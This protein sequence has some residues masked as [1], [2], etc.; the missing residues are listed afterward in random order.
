MNDHRVP[1][2]ETAS[3]IL[4]VSKSVVLQTDAYELWSK[5]SFMYLIGGGRCCARTSRIDR[6]RA[7]TIG[8]VF[9]MIG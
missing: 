3:L 1:S 8:V 7:K 5:L 9:N 4:I 2:P 6:G